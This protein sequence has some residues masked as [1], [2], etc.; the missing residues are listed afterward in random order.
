[1]VHQTQPVNEHNIERYKNYITKLYGNEQ[2][3]RYFLRDIN[4]QYLDKKYMQNHKNL[5]KNLQSQLLTVL[6]ESKLSNTFSCREIK[7]DIDHSVSS[8]D[9]VYYNANK[10]RWYPCRNF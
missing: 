5:F 8:G 1:M 2:K 10:N 4:P 3:L 7:E 9:F 6:T